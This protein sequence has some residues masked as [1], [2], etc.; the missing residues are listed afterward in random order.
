MFEISKE[1][2]KRIRSLSNSEFTPAFGK[3]VRLESRQTLVVV[4][5]MREADR[6]KIWA[7]EGYSTLARYC[8]SEFGMSDSDFYRK[9]SIMRTIRDLPEVEDKILEGKLNPTTVAQA[10]TFFRKEAKLK[11][12]A[13]S[14]ADKKEVLLS[15]EGLTQK[16]VEKELADLLPEPI[17]LDQ[18][19]HLGAGRILNQFTSD[20]SLDQKLNRLKEVL[21]SSLPKDPSQCE[22]LHKICD[23]ALAQSDPLKKEPA[24]EKNPVKAKLVEGAKTPAMVIN[25]VKRSYISVHTKREVTHRSQGRC[26]YV[27]PVSGRR[28]DSR[29]ALEFDHIL[30]FSKGGSESPE[31]LRLTCRAHNSLYAIREFGR[32]KMSEFLP[33]IR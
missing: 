24:K 29:T 19:K 3:E 15:L 13:V 25:R 4:H 20:E 22:L 7:L 18:K 28:C 32:K 1:E 11:K 9:L 5:F 27:D 26:S 30:P 10:N 16:S 2:L 31:N 21:A 6:R 12:K 23:I 8:V 33:S 17:V 14:V